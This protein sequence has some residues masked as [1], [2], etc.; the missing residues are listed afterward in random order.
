MNPWS[1]VTLLDV[2]ASD[3]VRV[4][5]HEEWY[6][7]HI[8]QRKREIGHWMADPLAEIRRALEEAVEIRPQANGRKLYIGPMIGR[9]FMH[10]N[11]LHVAVQPESGNC[12]V[13]FTVVAK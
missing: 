11:C 13:V 3:G 5:L 10:N 4:R 8:V 12:G 9:G 2:T 6:H 1:G 7:V